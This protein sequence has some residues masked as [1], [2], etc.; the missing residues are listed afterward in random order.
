ML[1]Y[2]LLILVL[3]SLITFILLHVRDR[4]IERILLAF[5]IFLLKIICFVQSLLLEDSKL[6]S[7]NTEIRSCMLFI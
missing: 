1:P 4:G 5:S 2:F 6:F 3:I 7:L